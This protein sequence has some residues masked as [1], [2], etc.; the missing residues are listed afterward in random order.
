MR[1]FYFMIQAAELRIANLVLIDNNISKI[2]GVNKYEVVKD[3][4]DSTLEYEYLIEDL[5]PIPLTPEIL[6]KCGLSKINESTI[7]AYWHAGSSGHPEIQIW[8]IMGKF[9][10]RY[11]SGKSIT[12]EHL[13]QLQNI[14]FAFTGQELEINLPETVK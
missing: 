4:P 1:L 8:H 2:I 11:H 9:N 12:C 14:Y 3:V 7:D 13:H 6:E 10:V 5:E